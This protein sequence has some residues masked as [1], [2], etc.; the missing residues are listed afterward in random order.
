MSD[1]NS[2]VKI[3]RIDERTAFMQLQT[4]EIVKHLEKI[5]GAISQNNTDIATLQEARR[6]DRKW[7][8][9]IIVSILAVIGTIVTSFFKR[10][11]IG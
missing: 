9:W 5:N 10:I 11:G 4:T 7:T 8:Y 3:G 6:Q 1:E 2:E